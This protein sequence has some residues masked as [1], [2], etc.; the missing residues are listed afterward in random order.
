MGGFLKDPLIQHV[1]FEELEQPFEPGQLVANRFRI[2]R[3]VASGGMGVV[4]EAFDEKLQ[5]RMAIKCPRPGFAPL[6]SPEL[7][8]AL[9]VR[10]PNICLV[11]DTHTANTD[12]GEVDF[13]TMEFIDGESIAERLHRH[14]KLKPREALEIGRQLCAGLAAAHEAGI[15]HRDLKTGNALLAR[16]ED[17]TFRVVITDFGLATEAR[18]EAELEGGTPRYMAPELRRGEKP[19]KASDVYAL[20]VI[21]YEMVTGEP[22]FKP[23]DHRD[24]EPDAKPLPPSAVNKDLSAVWDKAILP[25]LHVIPG[26]RPQAIKI[27]ATFDRKPWWKSPALAAA[28][29]ALLAVGTALW[30]K[31]I[32]LFKPADIRLAVMALPTTADVANLEA[33]AAADV[34]ERLAHSEKN[35]ASM[36]VIPP[37]ELGNGKVKTLAAARD[38]VGATHV[39]QLRVYRENGEVLVEQTLFDLADDSRLIHSTAAYDPAST[40][41]IPGAVAGAVSNAL[42]LRLSDSNEAISTEATAAYDG[43]LDLLNSEPPDLK[44]AVQQFRQ[45]A[46]LDAKSPLPFAGLVD[47]LLAQFEASKDRAALEQAGTALQ[48]A[49]ARGPA[50]IKVLLASGDFH[51]AEGKYALAQQAYARVLELQP[52][53]VEAF[54]QMAHLFDVQ[55]MPDRAIEY[56]RKAIAI[57]PGYYKSYE[58]FGAFYYSRGLYEEAEQQFRMQVQQSPGGPDGYS[59]LGGIL[60]AEGKYA[61]SID[62]LQAGL[63]IRQTAQMFN[64]LGVALANLHRDAEAITSYRHAVELD[65]GN[66]KSWNNIGDSLR[67]LGRMSEAMEPYRKALELVRADM[68]ANPDRGQSRAF[69]AY[70]EMRLGEESRA[71]EDMAEALQSWPNDN[72]VILFAVEMYEG[73]G[74]RQKALGVLNNATRALLDQ[75]IRHPD[76]AGISRDP[77][78]IDIRRKD[79]KGD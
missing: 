31:I 34:V 3:F 9:K 70:L 35:G 5:K 4:Y 19:T 8:A 65:P 2:M 22:P 14:G 58:W 47:A 50:S 12:S 59:N 37:G 73:L 44:G 7:E 66:Y 49:K 62:V 38:L 33:G 39:L 61:E 48:Q 78:F 26:R 57:D 77:R 55:S 71:R 32:E 20:G 40:G 16:K 36:S 69:V 72:Q 17:G 68:R 6:L 23:G 42:H 25:C 75:I 46:A 41:A 43:G 60:L 28:V 13:L 56:Y 63:K 18:L 21:L 30:P 29:V 45:A 1:D 64:N 53:N 10:H 51:Q 67:R 27:L 24:Q 15:I 54:L 74:Q 76:L 11:N 79:Q 52:R